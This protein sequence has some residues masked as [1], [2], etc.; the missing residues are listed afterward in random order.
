VSVFAASCFIRSLLCFLILMGFK[1]DP[2]PTAQG[3]FSNKIDGTK[4]AL[5]DQQVQPKK[6]QKAR[7]K[8]HECSQCDFKAACA[9]DIL[10]HERTHT[11][12]KPFKC[13]LCD[14]RCTQEK[15]MKTHRLTHLKD[16]P[17][18]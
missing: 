9:R 15:N 3:P 6:E 8:T 17:K 7:G 5:G 11:G 14:Y 12:E 13:D 2:D 10:R 16:R 1:G 18:V 4:A